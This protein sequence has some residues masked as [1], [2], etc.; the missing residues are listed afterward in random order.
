MTIR[1]IGFDYLGVVA[2]SGAG[3]FIVDE[4]L[5]HLADQLRAA[6]YRVGL[7]SNLGADWAPELS[8]QGLHQHFEAVLLSGSIGYAKPDPRAFEVLATRLGVALS[9][10][11][12]IDDSSASLEGT[13]ALGMTPLLYHNYTE[14]I[15]SL[16]QQ[17]VHWD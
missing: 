3:S 7:L 11:I 4:Q 13:P 16:R 17:G 12:F 8:Q 5:L 14:L 6:G 15:A 1:A 9:E 2:R 10:L